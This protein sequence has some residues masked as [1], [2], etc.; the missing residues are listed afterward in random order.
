MK[1]TS[2]PSGL[3]LSRSAALQSLLES[4][5]IKRSSGSILYRVTWKEKVTPS[6]RRFLAQR[7]S[8]ARISVTG[9]TLSQSQEI[10]AIALT[11]WPTP[12]S[13]DNR[14]RGNWD[15]PAIQRRVAIGKSIELSMLVGS[16]AW[17]SG[18][19]SPMASDH[20]RGNKEA[21]PHDTG[22]PLTQ[23]VPL[24][25]WPSP[26]AGTPAQNGNNPA[27]NTDS[28]RATVAAVQGPY[29]IRGKLDPSTM[30][31]G[32]YVETLPESQAGGPLNP[33]HSRWL[34]ALPPEWA[35]CAPMATRSTSKR[36]RNSAKSSRKSSEKDY[37]L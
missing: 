36:Q 27:G 25:G 31:I 12:M 18:W 20:S 11:G 33:E 5:L 28:S 29:A 2:G 1:D 22:V 37:D 4:K 7:A 24:A 19:C 23:Q 6:G 15:H 14:D 8:A 17:L 35:N 16:A 32:C 10:P 30:Q 9:I 34:M 26:Q 13:A 3:I 21:R